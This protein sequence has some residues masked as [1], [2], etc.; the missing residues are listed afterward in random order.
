MLLDQHISFDRA[1]FAPKRERKVALRR[2]GMAKPKYW[3]KEMEEVVEYEGHASDPHRALIHLRIMMK[4]HSP[5]LI[6][7]TRCLMSV[8]LLT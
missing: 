4:Y 2:V 1:H 5:F 7:K 8:P 6:S 3:M